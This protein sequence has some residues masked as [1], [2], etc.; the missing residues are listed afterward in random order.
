MEKI[1]EMC[2]K[3]SLKFT[4]EE[5][6]D[7]WTTPYSDRVDINCWH[8]PTSYDIWCFVKAQKGRWIG[9]DEAMQFVRKNFRVDDKYVEELTK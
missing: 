7:L 2:K 6:F 5:F 4:S 1:A 9:L 8:A 3:H